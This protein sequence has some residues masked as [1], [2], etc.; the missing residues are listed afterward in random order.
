LTTR[1]ECSPQQDCQLPGRPREELVGPSCVTPSRIIA[2]KRADTI[3]ESNVYSLATDFPDTNRRP[4]RG[5]VLRHFW[6]LGERRV[7]HPCGRRQRHSFKMPTTTTG[8]SKNETSRRH[9]HLGSDIGPCFR[10]R[11]RRGQRF[12]PDRRRSETG[13][14]PRWHPGY[15]APKPRHTTAQTSQSTH[16]RSKARAN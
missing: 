13:L 3:R 6:A 5:G 16:T 15:A 1:I 11:T 4:D 14:N 10:P 2:G 9:R 7:R 12:D 8:L